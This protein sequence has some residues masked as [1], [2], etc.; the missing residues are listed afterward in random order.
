MGKKTERVIIHG[1]YN[2]NDYWS[3]RSNRCSYF[4]R[5]LINC[6]HTHIKKGL[7]VFRPASLLQW[8]NIF[9]LTLSSLQGLH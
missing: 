5:I 3:N 2:F 7:P 9:N 8:K 1:T 4:I 6:I